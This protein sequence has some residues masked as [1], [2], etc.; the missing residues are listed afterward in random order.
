M[1]NL[2]SQEENIGGDSDNIKKEI[3]LLDTEID[4]IK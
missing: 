3:N 2:I 1:N 4:L